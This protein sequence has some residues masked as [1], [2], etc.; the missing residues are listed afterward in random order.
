MNRKIFKRMLVTLVTAVM[1]TGSLS[2]CGTKAA[3]GTTGSSEQS[4]A[5]ASSET[6]EAEA[7]SVTLSLFLPTTWNTDALLKGISMYEEAT[8]NKISLEAVPDDQVGDLLKTRMATNVDVPD[9]IAYN[10]LFTAAQTMAYL[11]PMDGE[12]IDKLNTEHLEAVYRLQEDGNVYCAPYGSATALG[13]IYNKQV[14]EDNGIEIPILSYSDLM[15]ACEI[16]KA[17]GVTPFSISN[18]EAWTTQILGLDQNLSGFT[19]EEYAALK[20]GQLSYADVVHLQTLL[21]NMVSLK[22]NGYINEDYMSTTM[23][24]SIEDVATGECA[25]TPAGDWSYSVLVTNFPDAADNVGMQPVPIMD[26]SIYVNIGTASKRF[27]VTKDGKAGNSEAAKDF[28]D[29]MMS[30]EVMQAMYEIEPGIC[31]IQG[32]TVNQ[33]SWNAE[34]VGYAQSIPYARVNGELN[35]FSTGD[36]GS[37]IQQLFG[38]KSVHEAL[39]YW[40]DDCAQVNKA[41]GTEG[42]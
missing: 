21:S 26:D 20:T 28:V 35:G 31:P 10:N 29:F 7:E 34:M 8:G 9:V 6:A 33:N 23:D 13:L 22:D 18:K 42:F 5:A 40:Y 4:D 2:G 37:S 38:G 25:M 30:D 41:A 24:M 1:L 11:V 3:E 15:E 32:L 27:W 14:M 17:N 36:F 39:E 19:A 12:W 16:L